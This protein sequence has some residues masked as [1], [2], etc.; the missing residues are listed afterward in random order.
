MKKVSAALA[1]EFWLRS[2]HASAFTH[3]D[4]LQKLAYKVDWLGCFKGHELLCIWPV[5]LNQDCEVVRPAFVYYV[6]PMWSPES[7]SGA[8]HRRLST[9]TN[10]YE[11]FIAYMAAEYGVIRASLPLGLNDV[12][13][14]DWWN[15]HEP[16]KPRFTIQPR[17]TAVLEA[18]QS[19]RMGSIIRRFRELRRRELRKIQVL[20]DVVIGFGALV[21][22]L[23]E[24][25]EVTLARQGITVG[26][27]VERQIHRLVEIVGDG[28]GEVV[29]VRAPNDGNK[30]MYAALLLKDPW[31]AHLLLNL[32]NPECRGHN[33]AVLG[34][35]SAIEW[36][37]NQGCQVFDFNGANSPNRGD[38]KHSYGAKALLYFDISFDSNGCH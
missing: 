32:N 7:V 30:L 15:Y 36:A 16:G 17:Y 1:L 27:D 8:E 29:T 3:P 12:R 10:V 20:D 14:F 26:E 21:E 23:V 31:S 11:S 34:M 37:K 2:P 19:E 25:Y 38:D 24:L 28:F 13:V 33:F 5:C 9:D 35:C 6:G 4:I 22:E 18:L